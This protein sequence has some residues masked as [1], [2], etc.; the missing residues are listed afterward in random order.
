M[1]TGLA[2]MPLTF[3]IT[4]NAPKAGA[5]TVALTG[6]LDSVTSPQLEKELGAV[7]E[8][9]IDTLVFDLAG[10]DFLSS[11]GIRVL[12]VAHKRMRERE[13]HVAMLRMQPQI[14]KVFE[15]VKALPSLPVFA[16]TA[17][18]DRYLGQMQSK[19]R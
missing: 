10:L 3:S 14:K 7:L 8:E 2:P 5:T 19:F 13:G 11:A 9:P 17:E 18:M 16:N 6:R 1:V 4:R 15:I 12:V